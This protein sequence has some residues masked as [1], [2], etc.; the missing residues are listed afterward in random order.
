MVIFGDAHAD[1]YTPAMSL[2]AQRAGLSG[3]QITAGGCVALLGYYEILSPFATEKSCRLLR[4]AMVRFVD[5]NPRLRL[6]ALAHR[7]SIYTGTSLYGQEGHLP[8]YLLGSKQ[9]ER[10]E[11]RSRAVLN[12]AL[13]QTLDYFESKGIQ[14]VLLGEM[15]PLGRDPIKCIAQAIMRKQGLDL[16]GRP[17]QEVRLRL[18]YVNGLMSDLAEQRKGVSFFSPVAVMCEHEWCGPI[19]KGVVAYRDNNHLNRMG[20]EQLSQAMSLTE[21]PSG[22]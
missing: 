6:V 12:Q 10:S 4:E 21:W 22:H 3:R 16:C 19:L 2:L 17:L 20:A 14:V 18:D 9:D 1:A 8:F 5:E 15:P 13:K 7:W 11:Q